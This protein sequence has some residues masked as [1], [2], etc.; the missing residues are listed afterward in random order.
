MTPNRL[1]VW[2]A[3]GISGFFSSKYEAEIA[4]RALFPDED[5]D[6]R[7][8]RIHFKTYVKEDSL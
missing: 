6:Q 5:P 4:V 8:A 2:F 1:D 7:Y 3:Y